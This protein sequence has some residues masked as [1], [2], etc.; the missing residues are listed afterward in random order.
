MNQR[1]L[2]NTGI[3]VSEISFGG[4]EIGLPYGIGV[5]NKTDMICETE[6][7]DLLHT[8]IDVGINFFDTARQYGNSE[9]IMGKAFND[10]RDNVILGTKC[11]HFLEK[12]GSIPKYSKL[13]K[14]IEASLKKSLEELQTDYVDIFMLHQVDM[15]ILESEDVCQIFSNLKKSGI[16]RTIGVSTYTIEETKKSIE[17]GIWDIIQ[18]PFNLMDQRQADLFSL[19]SQ[20]GIGIIVRSV[21]L[22]GLLSDR[23]KNLNPALRNVEEHI[24]QYDKLWKMSFLDLSTLATKFALSFY[25]VSSIL[26]GMDRLEYL[27]KS[28]EAANGDYFDKE[29]MLRAKRLAYPDP[30]FLNLNNWDKMGWL[31]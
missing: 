1:V 15:K 13:N 5:E 3:K 20:K 12:D 8:A 31:N 4:V 22:K 6:A 24:K 17:T 16:T 19:A 10:R 2:G 27:Y 25:E 9:T 21:L 23:G 14:I 30:E 18:L 29:T 7:I 28:L 11:I 26:V